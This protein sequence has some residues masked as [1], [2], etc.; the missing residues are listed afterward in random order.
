MIIYAYSLI[1][2]PTIIKIGQT[3]RDAETRVF[4]QTRILPVINGVNPT[5]ILYEIDDRILGANITDKEVHKILKKY[6]VY[7]EWFSCSVDCLDKTIKT[8]AEKK[9]Q[10]G[11]KY[12]DDRILSDNIIIDDNSVIINNNKEILKSEKTT[13]KLKRIEYHNK[14][15]YYKDIFDLCQQLNKKYN[16]VMFRVYRKNIPLAQ[17]LDM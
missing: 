15:Y 6:R 10:R 13:E 4:E 12:I 8:L 2:Y 17:A 11:L 9:K 5:K 3:Q 7:G 1:F 16:A 14:V